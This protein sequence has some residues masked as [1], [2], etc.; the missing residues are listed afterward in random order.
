[1]LCYV[2]VLFRRL[3]HPPFRRPQGPFPFVALLLAPAVLSI[4]V[5]LPARPCVPFSLF[6]PLSVLLLWPAAF[7]SPLCLPC[8]IFP[9]VF[10]VS[11]YRDARNRA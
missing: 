2:D 5:H 11:L 4:V 7:F 1:M 6:F 9:L 10:V 8:P 3:I